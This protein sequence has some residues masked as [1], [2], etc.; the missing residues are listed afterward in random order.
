M[1]KMTNIQKYGINGFLTLLYRN[2]FF[3]FSFCTNK[4]NFVE[5]NNTIE[6]KNFFD[7]KNAPILDDPELLIS[8][9]T[10]G[11]N[12]C[13]IRD[14]ES[15]GFVMRNILERE[16]IESYDREQNI[17]NITQILANTAKREPNIGNIDVA[18]I[19]VCHDSDFVYNDTKKILRHM[20]RGSFI[21]WHD[22][23]L[24]LAKKYGWIHSVCECVE[25]LY[26]EKIIDGPTFQLRNSWVGIYR[27]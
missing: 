13:G 22:F 10:Y 24:K 14:D 12:N 27:V 21:L 20:K 7:W 19:D 17:N 16:R 15:N 23:N 26:L 11:I 18:F 2:A 4:N 9:S 25:R 3:S 6:L 1:R 8:S 5:L